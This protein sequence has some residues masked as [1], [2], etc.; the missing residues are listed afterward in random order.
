M[1]RILLPL[2]A[3][4]LVLSACDS[5]PADSAELDLLP[6]D[7]GDAWTMVRTRSVLFDADGM[8]TDT[9][10]GDPSRRYTMAVVR[11]SI[12]DGERCAGHASTS[13]PT[14]G[15]PARCGAAP[16]PG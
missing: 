7:V 13:H 15:L 5:D 2:A 3:L 12:I 8:P 6:L 16:A 9:T 10:A 11:D 14:S 4:T 1:S